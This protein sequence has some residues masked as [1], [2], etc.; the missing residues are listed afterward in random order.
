M[1]N[2]LEAVVSGARTLSALEESSQREQQI[3]ENQQT[4]INIDDVHVAKPPL[5]PPNVCVQ[6]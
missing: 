6:L 4:A 3:E 5:E 1:A 2:V